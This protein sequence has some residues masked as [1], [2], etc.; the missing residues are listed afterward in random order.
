M[1]TPNVVT[2][3]EYGL[4]PIEY[5]TQKRRSTYLHLVQTVEDSDP[6]RLLYEQGLRLPFESS[7]ADDGGTLRTCKV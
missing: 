6:A 4:L 5:G 3:L 7:W 1:S 2:Y